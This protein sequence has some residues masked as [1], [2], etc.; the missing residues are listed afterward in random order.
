MP[1]CR[2]LPLLAPVVVFAAGCGLVN[3]VGIDFFYDE[4]R[5]PEANVHLGLAYADDD[6]PKHRL[7]LFLPLADSV[8]A[9]PWPVVVF[10]HGGGWTTGDRDYTF[11]GE[12]LYNNIGR[13]FAQHGIGT[14][15]VSYRLMPGATWRAQVDDV[16]A[17]VG[18][19]HAHIG[20]YG[21][22]PNGLF[23]M[24]H[25]A[26]AYLAAYA[27]L[28]ADVLRRTHVPPDAV[29]GVMPVSGAALDLT[30]RETYALEDDFDY[31]SWRFS[32]ERIARD[33]PPAEPF[34]WQVEAS[35]IT[36]VRADAPPFLML[37]AGG[38]TE[39]LQR[40]S[41]LLAAALRRMGV[42][43]RIVVVPGQSHTRIVP[44]LSRADKTAGPAML[45]FVRAQTCR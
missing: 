33:E 8:R 15:T 17:A 27:T 29:C 14:A 19:V 10:V 39:A 45:A 11:G 3:A 23:L 2:L 41:R 7:N 20:D 35:P 32:P 43:T 25:S 22:D 28:D 42:E 26:G 37:F 30:D 4:V 6:D 24:G 18:W 13:F 16:A 1:S 21:G 12:D 31:Y 5:L 34:A 9:A 44:T 40:Q 38:E 36:H